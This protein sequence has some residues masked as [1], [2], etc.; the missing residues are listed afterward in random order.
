MKKVKIR[1]P[2]T[3]ELDE[4]DDRAWM[5]DV[6][7]QALL[8]HGRLIHGNV[9][10]GSA[11][12]AGDSYR[13]QVFPLV[14]KGEALEETVR[15]E[16][17]VSVGET[18]YLDEI[19]ISQEP[20]PRRAGGNLVAIDSKCLKGRDIVADAAKADLKHAVIIGIDHKGEPYLH[21]DGANTDALWMIEAAKIELLTGGEPLF[22]ID[23]G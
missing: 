11:P 7:A 16:V 9:L 2:V 13:Y 8:E 4:F 18:Q 20:K 1:I 6:I 14:H 22:P 3:I 23:A 21:F 17:A 19:E 5:A 15:Q 12:D 10:A